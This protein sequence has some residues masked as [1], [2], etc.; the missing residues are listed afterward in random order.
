MYEMPQNFVLG[1]LGSG[2]GRAFFSIW[3]M[4]VSVLSCA[5]CPKI[6]T[7]ANRHDLIQLT[8]CCS[9]KVNFGLDS[10]LY[11][12]TDSECESFWNVAEFV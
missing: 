7:R 6:I 2:F 3:V 9:L 4:G 11:T 5:F 10:E 1:G 12:T 8:A